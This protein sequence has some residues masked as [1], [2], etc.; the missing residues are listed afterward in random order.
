MEFELDDSTLL[1]DFRKAI[2][3]KMKEAPFFYTPAPDE[4]FVSFTAVFFKPKKTASR[5]A[6]SAR[7]SN[8][9]L[10]GSYSQWN[11]GYIEETEVKSEM[12]YNNYHSIITAVIVLY[13]F[14]A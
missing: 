3:Q 4:N 1:H 10:C 11:D 6:V 14:N 9:L 8:R 2:P 13:S 7:K 5:K 12:F